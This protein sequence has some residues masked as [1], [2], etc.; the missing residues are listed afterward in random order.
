[1]LSFPNRL[2]NGGNNGDRAGFGW[3]CAETGGS[4]RAISFDINER[5]KPMF[6]YAFELKQFRNAL[7][8][9]L[10]ANKHRREQ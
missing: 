2:M 6:P 8:R 10:S 3:G 4:A 5:P 1:M 9:C 7:V